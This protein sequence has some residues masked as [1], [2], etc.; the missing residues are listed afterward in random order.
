MNNIRILSIVI[1]S[2]LL[3]CAA[4]TQDNV[5]ADAFDADS[6]Q[7]EIELTVKNG[8]ENEVQ[9]CVG[10]YDAEE[11]CWMTRGYIVVGPNDKTSISL[12]TNQT[13]LYYYAKNDKGGRWSGRYPLS[14]A[15]KAFYIR[16]ADSRF[17]SFAAQTADLNFDKTAQMEKVKF[18][19]IEVEKGE[20]SAEV[21]LEDE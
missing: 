12:R 18:K 1:S 11:A 9:V 14:I 13:K 4:L 3:P 19:L 15:N 5:G 7:P 2:V 16:L 8:T 21:L 20:S 10:W 17:P 6:D